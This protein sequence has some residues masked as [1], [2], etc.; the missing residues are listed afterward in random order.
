MYI[1]FVLVFIIVGVAIMLRVKIDP[2]TVMTIQNQIPKLII[3][4]LLVTFSIAIAGFLIDIMWVSLYLITGI[5]KEAAVYSP[6]FDP[7]N[8][9]GSTPFG[10]AAGIGGIGGI[11]SHAAGGIKGIMSSLFDNTFGRI[12][13]TF[14]FTALGAGAGTAIAPGIGSVI[15]GVVGG[16]MGGIMGGEAIAIV[17]GILAYIIIA[18]ALLWALMRL[19]FA[20]LSAYVMI[21]IDIVLAPFWIVAGLFPG[22]SINFTA[23]IRSFVANLS[24][25]PATLV[26]FLLGKFFIILKRLFNRLLF[27]LKSKRNIFGMLS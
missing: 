8:L 2:R 11:T 22:S 1:L 27:S 12:I 17:G 19:W 21:L 5:F 26:L 15:G 13:A 14:I 3:G 16:I 23:W 24:V 18:V 10:A 4:V 20:L 7:Q 25:F 6:S 9:V